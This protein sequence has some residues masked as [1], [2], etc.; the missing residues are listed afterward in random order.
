MRGGKEIEKKHTQLE[1]KMGGN[2]VRFHIFLS[3]N[4]SKE[5]LW[6]KKK[7][8]FFLPQPWIFCRS[9]W[10]IVWFWN[11]TS[12]KSLLFWIP[13]LKML[14]R[15]FKKRLFLQTLLKHNWNILRLNLFLLPCPN[16]TWWSDKWFWSG[17]SWFLV[18]IA[19]VEILFSDLFIT[20]HSFILQPKLCN[21]WEGCQVFSSWQSQCRIKLHFLGHW[22]YWS[23]HLMEACFHLRVNKKEIKTLK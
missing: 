13:H 11:V 5:N 18:T 16:Q 20:H 23:V 12:G 19:T 15:Q 21:N 6:R 2:G 10:G 22:Y 4:N 3:Y 17:R 8:F 7:R 9:F 14:S 1:K